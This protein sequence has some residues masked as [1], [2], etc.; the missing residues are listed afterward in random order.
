M[1]Q[2]KAHSRRNAQPFIRLSERDRSLI[3]AGLNCIVGN[4][5]LWKNGRRFSS[6]ERVTKPRFDPGDYNQEYMELFSVLRKKLLPLKN[7]GRLRFSS[8]FEIAACE[9][10]I[11]FAVKRHRHGHEYLNIPR[12]QTCSRRLLRRLEAVR[13]RAKRTE[14]RESDLNSYNE[15]ADRWRRL[16]R[17]IRVH[18][19]PCRCLPRRPPPARNQRAM[20]QTL[21]TL[22]AEELRSRG[23]PI[24]K[25]REL[26]RLVRLEVRNVRRGRRQYSVPDLLH[27]RIFAAARFANY[28]TL[29]L[30]K[31]REMEHFY[32]Q[33]C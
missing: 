13:K 29:R 24:P 22:T 9:L 17:W 8:S 21:V 19:P 6:V 2:T 27:D 26:R 1:N 20:V 15:N 5:S 28:V 31:R 11:R 4:Y 33:F 18:L 14:I 10:A 25:D 3:V 7:Y 12:L 23:G 30:E 32:E 16:V